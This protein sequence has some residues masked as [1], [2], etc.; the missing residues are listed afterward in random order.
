[1]TILEAMA[2]GVPVVASRVGGVSDM[3]EHESNGLLV[4]PDDP[5]ELAGAVK[6]LLTDGVLYSS[7]RAAGIRTVREK[8]TREAVDGRTEDYLLNLP[9]AM[10]PRSADDRRMTR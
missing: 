8:F 1:M 2:K 9:A 3:I 6:R 4:A 5:V 7:I 10:A